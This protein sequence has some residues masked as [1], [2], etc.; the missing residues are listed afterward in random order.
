MAIRDILQAAAGASGPATYIEDVFSTYLYTGNGTSQRIN[1]G[2][3]LSSGL[4]LDFG[5]FIAGGYYAGLIVQNGQTYAVIV[6]PKASGQTQLSWKT[7]MTAGPSATRTLNNGPEASASMNSSTYPAA[8]FCENLTIN[9]Y[10]DWYLPSRDEL[11]LCYRNLKPT[12]DT[13]STAVR[14]KSSY[15]YPEGNDVSGDT[16]GINRN[17][18]PTGS[19]YTSGFPSRSSFTGS[20]AFTASASIPYF[21]SSEYSSSFAWAQYF[22]NGAQIESNK[23]SSYYVRAIR[24]ISYNDA[25]LD[26]YRVSSDGGLVWIKSRG[27]SYDQ[28]LYDTARGAGKYIRSNSTSAEI[29]TTTY[30]NFISFNSNGFS[31]GDASVGPDQINANS[32]KLASWTFRK[33]PKFFDIVTYTGDGGTTKTI[34]HN[35]GSVPGCIIVKR[36]SGAQG[37]MV[38]H[39]GLSSDQYYLQLNTTAAQDFVGQ[40][41]N[42]TTTTFVANNG[43]GLNDNG[44]TYVAYLFAHNAGGFGAS[45]ADNVISCGSYT[46]T[47]SSGLFVNLGFEPQFVLVKNASSTSNWVIYDNMRGIVS[48]GDDQYLFPNTSGAEGPFNAMQLNPN[49]FTLESSSFITNNSGSTHIYIAIRRPMKT[50]TVGTDVFGI[51]ART[52][53]GADATV[54]GGS[55]PDDLAIIKNRGSAQIP[56]W[57]SRLTGTGYLRS[58]ATTAETAATTDILQANP[59]DVMNGVKVGTTSLI[60]NASGNTFINYLF[61]RAPG[62]F[63][64]VCY[65]GNDANRTMN[66]NLGVAPEFIIVKARGASAEWITSVP[67]S[68]WAN[69]EYL[70]LNNTFAKNNYGSINVWNATA[71]TSTV[72][73]LGT[74]TAVNWSSSTYIAYLFAS[75][76]GVSKVGS[77]TGNGSSQTINCGFTAGAR[78]IMIKRTDAAGSWYV[79]DTARGIVAGNDPY[80]LMNSTAAEVTSDDSIDQANSGFIVNQLA[81]TNI[82][83]SSATYIYLAIA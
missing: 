64:V 16:M 26:P 32:D 56:L 6:S 61:T 72:F 76:P 39:R 23:D 77:Y 12:T 11:E 3:A 58:S 52:G 14:S 41:W 49:G 28:M 50:P 40:S 7:S 68:G 24:R 2:I 36:T 17:S 34:S 30:Q 53:T 5:T 37:W 81:A 31:L 27:Q 25:L 79:W 29:S 83:V 15:T 59:W 10:S 62:F 75:C 19:A 18:N 74:S 21:S 1:N 4:N 22:T 69:T 73:S 35:L 67:G 43:L 44:V 66:H 60:T 80:F 63:D 33:Q 78:F 48:G 38:Y 70:I 57:T 8:Q 13:N 47:G 46:G 65:T 82:N 45:G 71:P 54:T 42:P 20:E 9:G 51:N 55:L